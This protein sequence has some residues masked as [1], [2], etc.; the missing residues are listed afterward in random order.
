MFLNIYYNFIIISFFPPP[1][2][3]PYE[4]IPTVLIK[5]T[6]LEPEDELIIDFTLCRGLKKKGKVSDFPVSRAKKEHT[7]K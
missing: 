7:A 2:P 4:M 5:C 3:Q 6:V 1:T